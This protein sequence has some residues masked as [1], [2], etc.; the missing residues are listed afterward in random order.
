L[1]TWK[2]PIINAFP[3]LKIIK[4]QVH[5]GFGDK[6]GIQ[7]VVKKGLDKNTYRSRKKDSQPHVIIG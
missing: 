2:L 6:L 3:L 1:P 7:G 5:A 4:A